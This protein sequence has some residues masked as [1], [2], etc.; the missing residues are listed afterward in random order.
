MSY[1]ATGHPEIEPHL[2]QVGGRLKRFFDPTDVQRFFGRWLALEH[3]E[4]V[5]IGLEPEKFAWLVVGRRAPAGA[6]GS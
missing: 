6:Q 4:E 1:G 3:V 5:R 2:Y